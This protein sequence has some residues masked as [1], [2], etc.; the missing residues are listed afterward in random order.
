MSS[1]S[2]ESISL[3]VPIKWSILIAI[4]LCATSARG[5]DSR[6]VEMWEETQR[7]RPEVIGS[8]ARIAKTSEPGTPMVIHGRI[9]QQDGVT[10]AAGVV[11]FAYHTDAQGLYDRPGVRGWRL[12]GWVRSNEQGRFTFHTIRPGSYPRTRTPAHVHFTIDSPSLP[13][14]WTEELQFDDDPFISS[15]QRRESARAGTFGSVR[16]VTTRGGVQ[17]VTVHL[18]VTSDGRF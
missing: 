2:S 11:V 16:P 17:H 4:G 5:Q 18:R 6:W 8:V 14:R 1:A 7:G 13:R 15:R 3:M 9:V 12:H 10:P